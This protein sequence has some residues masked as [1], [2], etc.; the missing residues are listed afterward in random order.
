LKKIKSNY[1]DNEF[2]AITKKNNNKKI[3]KSRN[4]FSE[5]STLNT[6]FNYTSS[7]SKYNSSRFKE[8]RTFYKIIKKAKNR[9]FFYKETEKDKRKNILEAEKIT[10]ELL[11]LKT[12]N[13]IKSYYIKKD[14]AKA[15]A[16]AEKEEKNHANKTIDPRKYIKYNL[17][18]EPKKNNLFKSFD[19]Q[20]MIMGNDKYRND[21]FNGVNKYKN[22]IVQYED[23]TGPIGFDKEQIEE[24]KRIKILEKMKMNYVGTKGLNF[25]NVLYK[26]KIKKKFLNFHFDKNYINVKTL[27]N[28]NMDKYESRI[29]RHKK[30]KTIDN[31]VDNNDIKTLKQIDSDAK[32]I[33]T[34]KE[35]M[36]KY[37][38]KLL[39]F[40]NKMNR[41]LLKTR[42]T[43]DF[44]SLRAKE[45]HQIKKK[46]MI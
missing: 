7:I 39:S 32:F 12:K 8:N 2:K 19:I 16:E 11:S 35:E 18:H 5:L 21:L 25:A 22:K 27:I 38:N 41:I 13:D 17:A 29:K 31:E 1:K 15:V 43:T 24:K 44:L 46:I 26:N 28:E 4:D 42:N 30:E 33:I 6:L 10:N 23:L 37:T 36:I 3:I 9:N 20:L 40:D 45:H 14:Y 34:D